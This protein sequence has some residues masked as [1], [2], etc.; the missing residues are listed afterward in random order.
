MIL[1]CLLCGHYLIFNFTCLKKF[2]NSTT[3]HS[4]LKLG[5][6]IQSTIFSSCHNF[7]V[8]I[9]YNPRHNIY[10]N[11]ISIRKFQISSIF[12]FNKTKLFNSKIK[13]LLIKFPLTMKLRTI[14]WSY[15]LNCITKIKFAF[16]ICSF[17]E[18]WLKTAINYSDSRFE[19][20][21]LDGIILCIGRDMCSQKNWEGW[22]EY[23][24]I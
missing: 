6:I 21:S 4:N 12:I 19:Q 22:Y 10:G 24:E 5:Y 16:L 20:S 1:R 13:W 23:S 8:P 14:N 15:F 7:K 17:N 3:F 11:D 2:Q 9:Q 18:K